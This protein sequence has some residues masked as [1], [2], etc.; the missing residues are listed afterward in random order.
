MSSSTT[1]DLSTTDVP[2]RRDIPAACKWHLA[3][4]YDSET[5]WE[6]DYAQV[7]K[8]LPSFSRYHHRVMESA[9]TLADTL[10][11][12][13]QV[14]QT[15]G[16]L[17]AYARMHRDEDTAD[18]HYQALAARSESLNSEAGAATSFIESEMIAAEP[19]LEEYRDKEPRL[20]IY[21]HYFDDLSR[22]KD[23]V[24]SS[25]EE[26]LLA[27][28]GEP[29][30]AAEELYNILSHADLSFGQI[31]DDS[32]RKITLS[33]GRYR[34]L[35][36]SKNRDT[37][38]EAFLSL[39]G[40]Y[41]SYQNTF[42]ASL[43]YNVK[44]DVFYAKT[45]NYA[46]SLQAALE[47]D[48][49]PPA[50]YENLIG[51]V[52]KNLAPLHRY[53]ALKKKLLGL[54]ELH[55]YDLY[56]PIVPDLRIPM[57]YEEGQTQVQKG[58]EPLGPEYAEQLRRGLTSGWID[59][60]ENKGK[61]TGAYSWGVYSV[62]PYVLLN[63][64]N[65]LDDALTLAHEMGHALHSYYSHAN[66]PYPTAHYATFCAEV[67][68]TT[69]E[70]LVYDYFLHHTTDKEKRLYLLHQYLEGIRATVYR[71]TLFAEF[72]KL[73]HNRVENGQS[74]TADDLN[75]IWH[76]L[77][78]EYYGPDLVVDT[79]IDV[80]WARVPHFYWDFY[81]YQYV[82]GYAA[83]TT[84]AHNIQHEGKAAQARYLS[85]LKS[86]GSD[87]PLELLKNAGVDMSSPLPI[88]LTLRKFN[89]L[90]DELAALA[91]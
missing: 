5:A 64:D 87:Y 11:L 85:F 39:F 19:L 63:Y 88:E 22:Q 36:Q 61:Q 14:S 30:A 76:R 24:L 34:G 82:T 44:K 31:T 89:T 12:R 80:E 51:T 47:T 90:V 81:V 72:E 21:R 35:I 43:A 33:E 62:H 71:Q 49:I 48:N 75:P 66:Q 32:G 17:S 68:S 1:A 7:K 8:I 60:Y 59:L 18:T 86:G 38:R 20:T 55:M 57:P 52:R 70:I 58:L 67:A 4:I 15:L 56:V 25:R 73:I 40:T 10:T 23:H 13:D 16:K 77:N 46:S 53:I 91:Q 42:A 29:L 69:N 45:R 78:E 65:R 79:P 28:A 3:D 2:S 26:A 84:L 27:R 54:T 83:A 50:V 37:R 74:L 6:T 41:Q 9:E